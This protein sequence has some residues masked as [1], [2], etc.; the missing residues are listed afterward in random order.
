MKAS[1]IKI[2]N[3]RGV[4]IPKVWIEEAGLGKSLK[5]EFKNGK[6]YIEPFARKKIDPEV[7]AIA[8]AWGPS[9]SAF[10]REWDTPE[11]DAAWA[12]LQ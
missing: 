1:L 8:K 11:E 5:L 12:Y 10:A 9:Y 3:S 7:L 2:G 6:I 4:R